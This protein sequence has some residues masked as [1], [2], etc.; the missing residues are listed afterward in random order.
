MRFGRE[1]LS[2]FHIGSAAGVKLTRRGG[3]PWPPSLGHRYFRKLWYP[4]TG[5]HGGNTPTMF[6]HSLGSRVDPVRSCW[7]ER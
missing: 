5:V 2:V 7:Q 1:V 4:K 3:T 6:P